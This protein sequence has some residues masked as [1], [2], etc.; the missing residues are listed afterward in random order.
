MSREVIERVFDPFYTTKGPGQGTG[1]GLS[2]VFGFVKQS[3]GHIKLY[4]E[5][6]HGTT[7][8]IYL[9]R[10]RSEGPVAAE[11]TSPSACRREHRTR[12]FWSSR[13]KPAS[14]K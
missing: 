12:S 1:L 8:K 3:S 13:T 2:Q 4:S 9:P 14:G 11:D 5:V 10:H 7:V 6:G